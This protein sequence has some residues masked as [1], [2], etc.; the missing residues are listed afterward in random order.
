MRIRPAFRERDDVEVTVLDALADR[1]E[2]GMTVFELRSHV[3]ADIDDLESALAN[4]KADGLIDAEENGHRT[5]ILVDERVI[6]DEPL[7]DEPSV[8]DAILEKFG[9]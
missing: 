2:E 8:V 9:L 6:P 5:V 4:L 1:G 3:D 7:D